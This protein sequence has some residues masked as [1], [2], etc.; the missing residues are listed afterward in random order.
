[1]VYEQE[2]QL[3][4]LHVYLKVKKTS[5]NTLIPSRNNGQAPREAWLFS[6]QDICK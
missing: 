2:I 6:L 4:T 5:F 1:M 3:F